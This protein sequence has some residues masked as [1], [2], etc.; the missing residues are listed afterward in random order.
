ME[1]YI[2]NSTLSVAPL[3]SGSGQQFKIIESISNGIPVITTKKGAEPF[4][5]KNNKE[6][7]IADNS[8][9]FAKAIIY[10]S[11]NPEKR[12]LLRNKAFLSIKNKFSWHNVVDQLEKDIYS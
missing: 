2:K 6:L 1:E 4:E 7:I 11:N 9:E 5:F 3:I 8:Q 10:L 12:K